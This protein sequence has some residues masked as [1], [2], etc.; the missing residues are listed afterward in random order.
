M[1]VMLTREP[2]LLEALKNRRQSTSERMAKR[3]PANARQ[4]A[5]SAKWLWQKIRKKWSKD[6]PQYIFRKGRLIFVAPEK[7]RQLKSKVKGRVVMRV[8]FPGSG[9]HG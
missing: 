5:R 2:L 7:R 9:K 1:G 6:H 4:A 3:N 8:A